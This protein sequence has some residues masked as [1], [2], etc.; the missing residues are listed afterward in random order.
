MTSTRRR[1]KPGFPP[2]GKR[3][4]PVHLIYRKF[5]FAGV[6]VVVALILLASLLQRSGKVVPPSDWETYHLKT[7]KVVHVVDGDTIHVDVPDDGKRFTAIRFWGVD[8]PELQKRADEPPDQPFAREARDLV[9]ELTLGKQVTLQLEQHSLRDRYGRLLAYIVLP[10]GRSLN[11]MLL[12]RGYAKAM[13][14]FAHSRLDE[15]EELQADARRNK[16]GLW[17][18]RVQADVTTP[19]VAPAGDWETYHLKKF[20]VVHVV[21]GDTI[22]VNH[23]DGDRRTTLVR[24]WGIDT[25]ELQQR[26]D[27]PPDQPFAREAL[28]LGLELAQGREVTLQL[29]EHSVRDRYGRLLAYIILPDGR[30]LNEIMIEQGLARADPRHPHGK[31]DHYAALQAVARRKKVGMWGQNSKPAAPKR[32]PAPSSSR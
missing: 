31:F 15:Y 4:L 11:A 5:G 23:P 32:E 9:R 22:R 29:E 13:Q 12:E 3:S 8:T 6:V 16:V 26:P 7:F 19:A 24:F 10:D 2:S 17:G 30:V 25:P 18:K 21:D 27:D 1:S 28:E 20:K 14:Q